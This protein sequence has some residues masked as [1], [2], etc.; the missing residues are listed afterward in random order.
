MPSEVRLVGVDAFSRSLLLLASRQNDA[1]EKAVNSVLDKGARQTRVKLSLGW[2]PPRTPTGSIPP[3]PPWRISGAL[4]RSVEVDKADRVGY[5]QWRGRMGP[6]I[7]Y[8]RIQEL[9]GV[10][11]RGHRTKLPPRPYLKP[12]WALVKPSIRGDFVA[13]WRDGQTRLA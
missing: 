9:G 3:A 10:T 12:A 13:A 2:H 4:S 11:G 5:G 6:Q 7:V 8:A 1:T